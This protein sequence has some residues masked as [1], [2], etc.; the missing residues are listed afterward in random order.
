MHWNGTAEFSRVRR[1]WQSRFFWL[2]YSS[3]PIAPTVAELRRGGP[4]RARPGEARGDRS[5]QGQAPARWTRRQQG[6]LGRQA[7][8]GRQQW[9]RQTRPRFCLRRP[10]REGPLR[11]GK[12]DSALPAGPPRRARAH[13][14]H[15]LLQ[16][17]LGHRH[18]ARLRPHRQ[19]VSATGPPQAARQSPPPRPCQAGS[20]RLALPLPARHFRRRCPAPGGRRRFGLG[21]AMLAAFPG[22]RASWP[23]ACWRALPGA[24]RRRRW[25]GAARVTSSWTAWPQELL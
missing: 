23:P 17:T 19:R 12:T 24:A 16:L 15:H 1:G 9:P 10:R 2:L 22:R 8:P 4:G 13:L 20:R 18:G 11:R 5:E 25:G 6:C 21:A 7:A 3:E 14:G